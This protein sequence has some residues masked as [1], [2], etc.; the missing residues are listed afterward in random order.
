MTDNGPIAQGQLVVRNP[1]TG[2]E[3]G[4]VPGATPERVVEAVSRAAATQADWA[5]TPRHER[6]RVLTSFAAHVAAERDSLALLL[7]SES[8]KPIAQ[9]EGEIEATIRLWRNYAERMLALS[10]DAHFADNQPG[11]EQDLVVTH[12]EPLGVVGAIIPFNF[13]S[14]IF[15]H[16]VAPAIAMG[17]AVVVK[18]SE[19]DP[20]TVAREVALLIEAGLPEGVVEV[21]FGG[22]DVGSLLAADDRVAAVSFTGSTDAGRSVAQSAAKRLAPVF[23]ELGGNDAF[24]VLD[25]ADVE[26]VVEEAISGRLAMNGQCCI[27]NK[28]VIVDRRLYSDVV[29]GLS[30][31]FAKL[32]VGDPL[33]RSTELG[34]LITEEAAQRVADQVGD[35]VSAGARVTTGGTV[36]GNWFAPTVVADI[37]TT[38]PVASDVEVFGPVLSVIPVEGTGE[39]V[40]VANASRYGLS[41]SVFSRDVSRAMAVAMAL[42]T[43]QVVI[44]GTGQYRAEVAPFGGFKQSGIGREGLTTSLLELAQN[45]NIVLR[46]MVSSDLR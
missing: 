4:E 37:K 9:A 7:A 31:R 41:G 27:S 15:T 17:N 42:E 21:I 35:M 23:L 16:K 12:H 20:L 45:K 44:N 24:V 43:G 38:M 28:R 11:H 40:K 6:Y 36:D 3:L 5:R 13:P 39:A 10:E 32:A 22:A 30:E 34:P 14:D 26:L 25:D 1:T 33:D 8:G 29:D 2:A 18:P 19:E 46:A